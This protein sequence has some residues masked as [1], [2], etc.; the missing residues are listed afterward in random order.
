[1]PALIYRE[2]ICRPFS[3]PATN[4]TWVRLDQVPTIWTVVYAY[5]RTGVPD[6]GSPPGWDEIPGARGCTPQ[7]C[8]F[9]DRY[10]ELQSSGATVYGLSTQTTTY[11]QEMVSR[12][13]LPFP[14]LSD[15]SLAL[16]EALRLPTFHYGEWTLL[17]RFTLVLRAG[18]IAH[19]IYPVFPP[20]ADAPA[21]VAWL[22]SQ[23]GGRPVPFEIRMESGIVL[24]TCSGAL[25]LDDAKEGA[26]AV[27][28]KPEWRGKPLVWDFRSAQLNVRAPEVRL[29]AMFILGRQPSPPPSRVAFVTA[30]DVDFGFARMFEVYREHPSTEVQAFRDYDEAVSW[31]RS[32]RT[33]RD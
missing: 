16:T 26:L 24:A 13:H 4:E 8:A 14:V 25:G 7:N 5:P 33:G 21:V 11:Q 18:R 19:V 27:W 23:C 20:T 31:A 15:A 10:A 22:R 2:E 17:K 32:P 12:L 30:R 1:M 29:L 6:Q 28:E 9:R 3:L